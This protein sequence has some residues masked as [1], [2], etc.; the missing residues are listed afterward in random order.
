MLN[1]I[2]HRLVASEGAETSEIVV[3]QPNLVLRAPITS[4]LKS[5]ARDTYLIAAQPVIN[6]DQPSFAIDN[7]GTV[8]Q[9]HPRRYHQL[10]KSRGRTRH[11]HMSK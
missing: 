8:N 4:K 6:E 7:Y 5:G 2:H 3:V 11:T 9:G 10:H 1:T